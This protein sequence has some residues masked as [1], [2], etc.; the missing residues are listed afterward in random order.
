MKSKK[1]ARNQREKA[2][3]R[4]TK[5][6]GQER[7]EWGEYQAWLKKNQAGLKKNSA[8]DR[9]RKQDRIGNKPASKPASKP[10]PKAAPK[11]APKAAAK[12]KPV[13]GKVSF[14]LGKPTRKLGGS[15]ATGRV[16]YPLGK[17]TRKFGKAS[18]G[19]HNLP[20]KKPKQ[21][22]AFFGGKINKNP[23]TAFNGGTQGSGFSAP[24]RSNKVIKTTRQRKLG[25]ENVP[26]PTTRSNKQNKKRY[27]MRNSGGHNR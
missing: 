27:T 25:G 11:P 18:K 14:P 8:E 4:G 2:S 26:M 17:P 13:A 24:K 21:G 7:R 12:K 10:A 16:T 23:R 19:R 3:D 5:K 6:L 1:Q 9:N 22:K 20:I 15:T